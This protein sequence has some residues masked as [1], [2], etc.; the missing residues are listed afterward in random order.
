VEQRVAYVVQ[1]RFLFCAVRG[2][3]R[4]SMSKDIHFAVAPASPAARICV[5]TTIEE[6]Q[7]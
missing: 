5:W 6:T 1:V 4:T 2:A 3:L 7:S